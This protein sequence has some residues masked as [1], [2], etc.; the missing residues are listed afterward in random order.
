LALGDALAVC[1]L[2]LRDF[3]AEDFARSHPGGKLGRRLLIRVKD[4]MRTGSAIPSVKDGELLSAALTE[5]TK[6]GL[7]L[8]AV[9][10][11]QKQPVG[12]FTDG[13]LRRTF[14]NTIHV[15]ELAVE[16]VEMMEQKK[17]NG[18]LVVDDMGK[19]VGAFNMHD[20]LKAKVV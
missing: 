14:P 6:K 13:D 18:L 5:M 15:N 17:I 3:T 10:N 2:N 8:T 12:V 9:V 20:L 16:A 19:L 1:V 7:G 11:E 4:V